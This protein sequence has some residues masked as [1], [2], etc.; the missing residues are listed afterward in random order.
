[1]I[2]I[3]DNAGPSTQTIALTGSVQVGTGTETIT[4][5][6]GPNGNLVES[7]SAGATATY[8]LNL[9]S[10]FNGTVTFLQCAG[11]PSTATCTVAPASIT[12]AANQSVPFQV[13][14]ATVTPTTSSLFDK[15][16]RR[17]IPP[18]NFARLALTMAFA[19]LS[20]F[21]F[22]RTTR[23]I[24]PLQSRHFGPFAFP[25]TANAATA[26]LLVC[27]V[28]TIAGCGGASTVATAPTITPTPTATSQTYTIT[29]TPRATTSNNAVIPNLQPIQLTL[30]LD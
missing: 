22:S 30:I 18:L 26:A 3:T 17:E 13:T 9:V 23:R 27:A 10:T 25:L 2:V 29:I 16:D 14:V 11:A 6:P 28:L 7:I 12:V 1:M 24:N 4:I 8:L 5:T 20:S 21:L 15:L 19:L